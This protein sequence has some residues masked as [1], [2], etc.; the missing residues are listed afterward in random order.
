MA[1][2]LMDMKFPEED[3]VQAAKECSSIYS[4]M[5]YLQQ[6]CHLCATKFSATQVIFNSLII[7]F[8]LKL[9]EFQLLLLVL[10]GLH[11]PLHSLVLQI[12]CKGILYGPNP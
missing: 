6:E 12:L 7:F 5:S 10:D 4:A 1:L 11:A 2:Q 3:A 8:V 9:N